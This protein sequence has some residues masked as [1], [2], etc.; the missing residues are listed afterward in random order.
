MAWLQRRSAFNALVAGC[1]FG[2]L[3]AGGGATVTLGVLGVGMALMAASNWIAIGYFVVQSIAAVILAGLLGAVVGLL[4]AI[5]DPLVGGRL[6]DGRLPFWAWLP[7][8]A[9]MGAAAGAVAAFVLTLDYSPSRQALSSPTDFYVIGG[10]VCGLVAGPSF[11]W[12]FRERTP[13]DSIRQG[14]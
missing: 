4:V 5:V 14:G 9:V 11:G 2:A 8:G 3:A 6:H 12:L 7:I 10:A 13:H 1:V